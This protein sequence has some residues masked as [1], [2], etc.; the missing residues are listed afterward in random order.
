M[1]NHEQL[2]D[3]R[4][5]RTVLGTTGKNIRHYR[6]LKSRRLATG[7]ISRLTSITR[8]TIATGAG[9]KTAAR[10]DEASQTW[11]A[12]ARIPHQLR[13]VQEG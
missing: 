9:W 2:W 4:R 3:R 1:T 11:Y 13:D 10:I 12:A 7:S 8:A 6:E 5:R